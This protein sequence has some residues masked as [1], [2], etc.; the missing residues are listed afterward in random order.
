MMRTSTLTLGAAD[1][2]ELLLD[3]HAQDLVLRLARHVGDFIDVEN[4]A[5]GLLQR[6]DLALGAVGFGA[7][8]LDLHAFGRDVGRTQRHERRALA[9][10]QRVDGAR[11]EFLARTGR[12]DDHD[13][14]VGRRDAFDCL[15]QLAHRRRHADQVEGFAAALLEV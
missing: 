8:Q 14:A 1:P 2:L 12:T 5:V 15:A 10:R 3:Q 13:A 4:A 9:R 11:G 7:E 6:A